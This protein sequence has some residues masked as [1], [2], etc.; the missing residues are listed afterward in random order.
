MTLPRFQ[1]KE[2]YNN[3]YYWLH[4][5]RIKQKSREYYQANKKTLLQKIRCMNC[6]G[7]YSLKSMANHFTTKKHLDSLQKGLWEEIAKIET[8]DKDFIQTLI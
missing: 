4:K 3:E 2:D 6:G 1:S 7:S 8:E 5:E